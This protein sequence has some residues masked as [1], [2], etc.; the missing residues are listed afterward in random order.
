M[1]KSLA[2][3]LGTAC[4]LAQA[5]DRQGCSDAIEQA[6]RAARPPAVGLGDL[7]SQHCKPWPPSVDRISAAVMGFRSNGKSPRGDAAWEVVVALL[8]ARTLRP[9]HMRWTHVDSDALT[10]IDE[11]SFKLDTAAWQLTPQLRALGLRFHS[12]AYG[13]RYAEAYWGDELT[14]FVP[15]GAG[16][17]A[18]MGTVTQARQQ[19]A[20]NGDNWQVAKLSL[21]MGRPGPAGWADIVVTEVGRAPQRWTYRY[22]GKAYGLS[23]KQE[24]FWAHYCCALSW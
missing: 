1:K 18:V 22:D 23:T 9:L 14:L 24:P 16:L 19:V 3:A 21:A 4:A 5:Q 15:D 7:V 11:Y 10:G 6:L 20:S 8:D 17:R 12:S 13:S 2:L